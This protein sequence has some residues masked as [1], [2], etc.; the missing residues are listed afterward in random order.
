MPDVECGYADGSFGG[1]VGGGEGRGGEAPAGVGVQAG[2]IKRRKR[3]VSTGM[4]GVR[5][6]GGRRTAGVRREGL[7]R[8]GQRAVSGSATALSLQDDGPVAGGGGYGQPLG[9]ENGQEGAA[10]GTRR[11]WVLH[12][13]LA[14]R[15]LD[16]QG[17]P[18]LA[19]WLANSTLSLLAP[20]LLV[21]EDDI[22]VAAGPSEAFRSGADG[23][24]RVDF[25]LRGGEGES[26]GGGGSGDIAGGV[27]RFH[28]A[29]DGDSGLPLPSAEGNS[30]SLAAAASV[31][32]LLGDG[33][34]GDNEFPPIT[35]ATL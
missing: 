23:R 24:I 35:H 9:R 26:G 16:R 17:L 19:V 14:Q 34:D 32:L 25:D 33:P 20:D 4:S 7:R 5:N 11:V 28:R 2:K 12:N 29:F 31:L 27:F 8:E 10:S 3:R 15:G 1:G 13:F 22:G 18:G 21:C 6:S 30:S